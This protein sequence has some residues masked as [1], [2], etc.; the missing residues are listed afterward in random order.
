VFALA[1]ERCPRCQQRTLRHIAAI[2][3]GLV[4]R[5][6]VRHL[7]LAADAPPIVTAGAHHD[8][9]VFSNLRTLAA[10]IIGDGKVVTACQLELSIDSRGKSTQ[11]LHIGFLL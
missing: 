8:A 10:K 9:A 7:K 3:Y 6:I 2:T 1:M 11:R 4:I 5:K